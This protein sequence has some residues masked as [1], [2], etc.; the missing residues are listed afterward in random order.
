MNFEYSDLEYDESL[1]SLDIQMKRNTNDDKTVVNVRA[2]QFEDIEDPI[3]IHVS[4]FERVNSEYQHLI[5]TSVNVCNVMSR[6]KSHPIVR[7]ILKELLRSSNFPTNC[8]VKKVRSFHRNLTKY[9][10]PTFHR[11]FIT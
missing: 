5:N 10:T 9:L 11:E 3:I 7:L 6:V 4:H 1:L 2:E 8:P